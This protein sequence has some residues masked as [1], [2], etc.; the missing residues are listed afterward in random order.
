M[1]CGIVVALLLVGLTAGLPAQSSRGRSFPERRPSAIA[2]ADV[3][4]PELYALA[5]GIVTENRL[6]LSV[7]VNGLLLR[8]SGF[9]P[10][11]GIGIQIAKSFK[12]SYIGDIVPLPNSLAV[13]PSYLFGIP[14]S[15][16]DG[17]A[18]CVYAGYADVE[19]IGLNVHTYLGFSM[20]AARGYHPMYSPCLKVGVN[21][22]FASQE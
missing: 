3:G 14:K 15:A 6:V 20:S 2:Q 7:V 1:Q 9:N 13:Q 21:Y 5:A 16:G 12:T 17:I 11:K 10:A 19:R 18:L 22:N 8:E 4:F